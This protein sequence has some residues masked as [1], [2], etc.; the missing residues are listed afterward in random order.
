MI[1]DHQ[2]INII[3]Y[4]LLGVNLTVRASMSQSIQIN[5]SKY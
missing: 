4:M 3:T 5:R 1:I 2:S